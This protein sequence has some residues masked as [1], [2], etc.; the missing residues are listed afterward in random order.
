I[1]SVRFGASAGDPAAGT[2]DSLN[3]RGA[4]AEAAGSE[5]GGGPPVAGYRAGG[6]EPFWT[7]TFAETSMEFSDMGIGDTVR[8]ARPEP[9]R[10][11][12]GW[13]FAASANGQPFVVEIENRHCNDSM[14]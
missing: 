14:S 12:T 7:L 13:R 1:R 3:G 9:E 8:A 10:L 2:G 6:N 11:P 4:G 5:D